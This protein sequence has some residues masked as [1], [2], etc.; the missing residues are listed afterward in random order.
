MCI[1][2]LIECLLS[3]RHCSTNVTGVNSILKTILQSGYYFRYKET[4]AQ[5]L[6]NLPKVTWLVRDQGF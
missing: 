5:R 4:E 6:N 3:A 1:N 2:I